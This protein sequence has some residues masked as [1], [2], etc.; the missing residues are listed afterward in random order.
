MRCLSM[1]SLRVVVFA[2]AASFLTVAPAAAHKRVALV[3]GNSAYANV[4]ALANPARDAAAM[5]ALF[6]EAGFAKVVRADDLGVTQMRRALRDFATDVREA[7]IAVVF[8]AGHGLEVNGVNYLI[9]TDALLERDI[10]VPDEAVSLERV[11]ELLEGAKKLRLVVLDACRH[12]PFTRTIKRTLPTRSIGRGLAEVASVPSDTLVAFAA[13][14]G[15]TAADGDGAN[16]PYTT[17]LLKHLTTPGLDVQLALRRVRDEVVR[18]TN[19]GQE[20][21]T[22]GSLGGAEVPLVPSAVAVRPNGGTPEAGSPE[23][24]KSAN[25]IVSPVFRDPP[26]KPP[27]PVIARPSPKSPTRPSASPP[28][29]PTIVGN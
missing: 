9:P 15:S 17:A 18:S 25:P 8:F 14:A 13:K 20:P 26:K 24:E 21:F 5:E 11:N 22:Y 6:K 7:D 1:L 4:G 28:S 23:E 12:N 2:M 3:I 27:P 29:M 10:D 16:S 19:R